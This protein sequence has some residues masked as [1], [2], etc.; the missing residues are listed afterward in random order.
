ME[1]VGWGCQSG[2]LLQTAYFVDDSSAFMVLSARKK[3]AVGWSTVLKIGESYQ[4]YRISS[5]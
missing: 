5:K 1:K 3:P 2:F 4:R